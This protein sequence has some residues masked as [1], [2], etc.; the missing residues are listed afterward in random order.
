M[1]VFALCCALFFRVFPEPV[2]LPLLVPEAIF[3]D[4]A[5]CLASSVP[6]KLRRFATSSCIVTNRSA[7]VPRHIERRMREERKKAFVNKK[8]DHRQKQ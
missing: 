7:A 2:P 1:I 5:V 8:F 6:N 4:L 3:A